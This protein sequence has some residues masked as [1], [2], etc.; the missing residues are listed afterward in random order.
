MNYCYNIPEADRLQF[1]DDLGLDPFYLES[2]TYKITVDGINLFLEHGIDINQSCLD[3]FSESIDTR[4]G[5]SDTEKVEL[6]DS[7]VDVYKGLIYVRKDRWYGLNISFGEG[8]ERMNYNYSSRDYDDLPSLT[9][10]HGVGSIPNK[11]GRLRK[12]VLCIARVSS[13]IDNLQL[14]VNKMTKTSGS[15]NVTNKTLLH[16]NTSE[17]GHYLQSARPYFIE[18]DFDEE[19]DTN[20]VIQILFNS[21]S[22]SSST[23]YLYSTEI[24]FYYE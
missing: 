1:I 14:Y 11:K 22:S 3:L 23:R 24:K 5:G 2:G 6:S 10:Y 21:S 16:E 4:Y 15:S 18:L 9:Y 8:Y 19:V 17:Q 13:T 12:I 7:Y 20:D